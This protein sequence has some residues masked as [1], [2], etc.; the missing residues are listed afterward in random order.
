MTTQSI[1]VYRSQM[2][3]RIDQSVMS[4]LEDGSLFSFM[5]IIMTFVAV[6][7]FADRLMFKKMSRKWYHTYA[8]WISFILALMCAMGM[9]NLFV[10]VL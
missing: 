6:W 9:F 10:H 7:V 5:A 3:A 1:V 4:G 8:N 2:E